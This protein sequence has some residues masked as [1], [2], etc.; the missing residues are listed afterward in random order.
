MAQHRQNSLSDPGTDFLR[1]VEHLLVVGQVNDL[2]AAPC[3]VQHIA[4]VCVSLGRLGERLEILGVCHED[5]LDTE[6]VQHRLKLLL[7]VSF[8]FG[9][10]GLLLSQS[11]M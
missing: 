2:L 8:L 7:D 4:E 6:V 5:I 10:R 1:V 11:L 9:S 3:A